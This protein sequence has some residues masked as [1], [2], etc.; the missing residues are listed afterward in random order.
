MEEKLKKKLRDKIDKMKEK[1]D[2]KKKLKLTL[3]EE[4]LEENNT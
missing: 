1:L 4:L 2:N 3:S